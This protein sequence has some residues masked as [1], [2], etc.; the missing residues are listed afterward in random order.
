MQATPKQSRCVLRRSKV[1]QWSSWVC[2]FG[3]ITALL[4]WS[5]QT[6][7]LP[8]TFVQEGL[9]ITNDGVLDGEH[10]L[11][12]RIYSEPTGR[13]VF[14]EDHPSTPV[15]EG[16]YVI[17]VGSSR[18]LPDDIFLSPRLSVSIA[19]D[20]GRELLPR[21]ELS[22][23]PAAFVADVANDVRGALP[24]LFRSTAMLSLTKPDDGS[25]HPW[26]TRARWAGRRRRATGTSRT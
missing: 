10:D 3:L 19:V 20:G 16:Y 12:V 21:I 6:H 7:A 2:F 9:I 25:V 13:M 4:L 24:N 14:E 1:L 23:V 11:R 15:I 5:P 17:R 22:K 18:P 8:S 26:G